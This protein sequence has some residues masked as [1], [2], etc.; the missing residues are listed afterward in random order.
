MCF[1]V[2]GDENKG[3]HQGFQYVIADQQL[4]NETYSQFLPRNHEVTSNLKDATLLPT[5]FAQSEDIYDEKKI[6][7]LTVQSEG[8]ACIALAAKCYYI[9]VDDEPIIRCCEQATKQTEFVAT[10]VASITSRQATK[11]TEFVATKVAERDKQET[12]QEAKIKL[13]SEMLA[14]I[15][16]NDEKSKKDLIKI[17]DDSLQAANEVGTLESQVQQEKPKVKKGK[18]KIQQGKP[19]IQ[20]ETKF[21]RERSGCEAIL[22]ANQKIETG[23][24]IDISKCPYLAVVD[25]DVDKKLDETN[26]K[27]IRDDIL[28]QLNNVKSLKVGLAQ[29]AHGGIHI[30]CH[31]GKNKLRQ[32]SMTG[33][34]KSSANS[35]CCN[36]SCES[37]PT[38]KRYGVDVFACV[39]PYNEQSKEKTL[40]WVVLP[41]SKVKD[42]NSDVELQYIDLNNMWNI[43][44]LSDISK[45]FKA[46]NF[47]M[48]LILETTNS[49]CA[50]KSTF[51]AANAD[52]GKSKE[53]KQII[54]QNVS[55]D[56]TQLSKAK[57][58]GFRKKNLKLWN[59]FQEYVGVFRLRDISFISDEQ[60][61]FSIFQGWKH[62]QL[63]QINMNS[64][65]LYL[66]LIREY[67]AA[68]D[69]IIYEY[70]L[71]WISFILQNPGIKTRV[72]IVIRGVQGTGKNTFI[73]VLCDLM[74]G[75][76]AK[77]IT[78]IEEITGNFNAVIEN[79]SLI[80]LNELKNFTEQRALNS[81]ALQSIITDDVQRINEKFVARRDSQNV[82]NL[83]FV[84]NNYCPV[85][86][87]A[88]DRRY[89][90][91]Q[92]PDAHRLNYEHFKQIHQSIKQDGFYDNL[93]TF[94][95]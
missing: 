64:I 36:Q 88:T 37:N 22:P 10:K 84:S 33:I 26:R 45:V 41:D 66:N 61:V 79:K 43:S 39:T 13:R 49:V 15:D 75:Y 6:N 27:V 11:Q 46:L 8:S 35:V 83:I 48:N 89:L 29:T 77:N 1:A 74:A 20:Q 85:K 70:I 19:K 81:N 54:K 60:D 56:N 68:N 3:I 23:K 92:T 59:L 76:S 21:K 82:S 78:D 53:I 47:D 58:D 52:D 67:I 90:V 18:T 12:I 65:Q 73:D 31:M 95:L 14:R 32:N 38:N 51:V 87:E 71:N 44:K 16:K 50:L 93:Y 9:C 30:Y 28:Q 40:R 25:I 55:Q 24:A 57:W 86:I 94:F 7:G 69:N 42:K 91:C 34:I 80:V 63:D 2:A 5:S 62:K 17:L 4:Y 72:A